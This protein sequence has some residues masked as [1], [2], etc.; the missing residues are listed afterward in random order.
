LAG[1]GHELLAH[2]VERARTFF[3]V[4]DGT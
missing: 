1:F 3:S 2:A 4:A